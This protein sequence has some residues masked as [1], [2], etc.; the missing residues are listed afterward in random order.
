MNMIQDKKLYDMTFCALDLETTGPSPIFHKIIEIGIIKFSFQKIYE[1]YSTLIN[2][3]TAI[4]KDTIKIHGI[5][6][7]MV[8]D[9]PNIKD[10]LSKINDLMSDSILVIQNPSFDL[11]FLD[12]AYRDNGHKL[13][14]FEAFDTVKLSK[15]TFPHMTN[16]KL[17]NM[18]SFL[19]LKINLH[20]ALPDAQVCMEIFKNIIS[21]KDPEKAW[22]LKNLYDYHGKQIKPGIKRKKISNRKIFKGIESGKVIQIDY[23][24]NDGNETTRKIL[25]FEFVKYGKKSFISAFCYLRNGNRYFSAERI[26]RIH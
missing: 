11:S 19:G 22:T 21:K 4:P 23:I 7:N 3:H 17:S 16:H 1:E 8:I 26:I 15:K 18:C 10:V 13:I 5:T 25:P 14:N 12:T 24:D 9:A 2:P 6:D 20:R